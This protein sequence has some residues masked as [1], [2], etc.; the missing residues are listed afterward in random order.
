MFYCPFIDNNGNKSSNFSEF[1]ELLRTKK[2][3]FDEE[4]KTGTRLF[5]LSAN[6]AD[7]VSILSVGKDDNG[8][9][10]ECL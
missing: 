3:R 10:R 7:A 9:L 5:P 4:D 2:V 6:S 1:E 8:V